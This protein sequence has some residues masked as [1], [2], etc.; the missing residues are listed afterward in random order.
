MHRNRR[1]SLPALA[2]G[3]FRLRYNPRE[4]NDLYVV[5]NEGLN[6]DRFD[7]TPVPPFVNA[8]TLV[9]KYSYT[10]VR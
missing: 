3:N 6:L 9:M 2:L 1:L 10:F 4:G 8:R 7:R 5:F